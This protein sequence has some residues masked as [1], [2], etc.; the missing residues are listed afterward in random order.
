MNVTREVILDLL[1]LYLSGEASPATRALVEEW[2]AQ[3]P[4]L[5]RRAREAAREPLAGAAAA[6][7]PELELRA[8]RRTRRLIGVQ[9]WLFGLGIALTA[10]GLATRVEFSGG[11]VVLVRPLVLDDPVPF[12]ICLAIALAFWAG[13]AAIR[14]RLR[15]GGL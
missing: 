15:S 8:L 9:K 1:P 5:A 3:D 14:R 6:P 12:G 2:L 4:E 13:Y 7:P 10:I 11:R